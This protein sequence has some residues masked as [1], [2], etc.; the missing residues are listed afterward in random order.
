MNAEFSLT[1]AAASQ[2]YIMLVII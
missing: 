1:H 2:Q